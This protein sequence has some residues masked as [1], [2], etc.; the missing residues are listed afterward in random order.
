MAPEVSR[1]IRLNGIPVI[2]PSLILASVLGIAIS[3]V[4]RDPFRS[5]D[6]HF[7]KNL[8]VSRRASVGKG[9]RSQA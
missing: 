2:Q 8:A 7:T 4:Q 5:V 9:D 3:I 1:S 6:V